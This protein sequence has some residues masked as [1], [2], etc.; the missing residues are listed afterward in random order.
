ML[1]MIPAL[2]SSMLVL[3]AGAPAGASPAAAIRQAPDSGQAIVQVG[4]AEDFA[5]LCQVLQPV[6]RLRPEGDAWDRGEAQARHAST[7]AAA[8]AE[9][10]EVVVPGAK[11][12]FAPYDGPERRLAL[13][14]P[15]QLPVADG[16]TRLWPVEERGLAVEA[17]AAAARR[18]L[19]AQRS[20]TLAL[21][22]VFDLDDDVTCGADARG[23]RF[24]IPV[25]PVSWRWIAGDDVVAHGGAATDR[26][27]LTAAHGARPVVEV[28]EPI[29]GPAEAKKAVLA[30]AKDLEGCYAQALRRNPALDGVLVAELGGVRPV[31]VADSVGDLDLAA[32]VQRALG[33]ASGGVRAAVPIR[34][35]L[36]PPSAVP[37]ARPAR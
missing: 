30:R 17:G 24:T 31:I 32:C 19:E 5:R 3:A 11:L 18:I 35:E 16:A 10:Y 27:L 33:A 28:G 13:Q 1:A 29:A 34:F 6:E 14:E 26:P 2:V 22:L 7:R 36:E 8:L 25:S 4:T 12:A 9:R 21:A 23:T 15:V 20:G 37:A